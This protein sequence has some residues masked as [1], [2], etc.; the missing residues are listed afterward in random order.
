MPS[1]SSQ[2]FIQWRAA[3]A[4]GKYPFATYTTLAN[5]TVFIPDDTFIDAR[6]Y[7]VGGDESLYLSSVVKDGSEITIYVGTSTTQ[8]LASGTYDS[9]SPSA[10]ITMED[11]YGRPA[12]L[13]LT[14]EQLMLPLTGWADGTYSF[15]QE[16]TQFCASVVVPT[17]ARGVRSL[18][19]SRTGSKYSGDVWLV[20]GRGVTLEVDNSDPA[21]P[22]ITV[23]SVGEP[24]YKRATCEET[25]FSRPCLLKTINSI[26]AD[27]FGNFI[28][29]V[30]GVDANQSVF[31]IEPV[32]SGLQI[33][34]IGRI[35]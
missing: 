16:Q 30:C 33:R 15:S 6:L 20:G 3:N 32:T 11:T 5:D 1:Q 7:P 25:G 9:A 28:L 10:Q 14:S 29:G 27:E 17:S 19:G 26:P 8:S 23:H 18:S 34:T 13:L 12:G 2:N 22:V 35:D 4:A 21:E 31:R 24:L